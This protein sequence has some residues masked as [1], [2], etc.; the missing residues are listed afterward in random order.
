MTNLNELQFFFYVAETGSFTAAAKR[1]EMP[2]STISR[3]LSRLEDRLG[4]RLMERT[5][6]R[7]LLTEAGEVYLQYCR[8]AMEEL[9]QAE[10]AVGEMRVAPRGRLRV[11][12]PILFSR[13]CLTPLVPEFLDR[14][15]DVQLHLLL[16]EDESNLLE[17]SLDFQIRTGRV[18]DSEMFVR[19]LGQ[20][21]YGLY[22]SPGYV[23][24]NGA[25]SSPEDLLEHDCITPQESGPCASWILDNG[26]K[27]VEIR[28]QPRFSAIDSTILRQLALA[29]VGITVIPCWLTRAYVCEGTLVRLLPEWQ[30]EPVDVSAVYPSPLK[31]VPNARVFLEFLVE[32]LSFD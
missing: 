9:Q 28:P 8:K 23:A 20:V 11:G 30:P 24:R 7:L 26:S 21:Q 1:L 17:S 19:Y 5:T 16:G 29:G 18:S 15:P 10:A 12:A 14:Y 31:L 32:R 6:R 4:L 3:G 13:S 2:K 25:P 27:K 22:A